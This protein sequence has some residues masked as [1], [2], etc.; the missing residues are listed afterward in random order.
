M[1][2]LININLEVATKKLFENLNLQIPA[3]EIHVFLGQN[4]V[5]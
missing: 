3:G 5:G 2:E 4:G 1:L